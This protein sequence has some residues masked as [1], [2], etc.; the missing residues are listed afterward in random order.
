LP[1]N[2][3]TTRSINYVTGTPLKTLET[4]HTMKSSPIALAYISSVYAFSPL[5]K[6][7]S[8]KKV[9]TTL[10]SSI[11]SDID[12]PLRDPFGLYP[13]DSPERKGGLIDPL[14]SKPVPNNV[15]KD[16]LNLYKDKSEVDG[17]IQMSASLPFL[18]RPEMLDGT[19]PGDRGF[20]PFNFSSDKDS[21][22]WYRYAEIKHSRLAMLVSWCCLLR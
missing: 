11:T 6:G 14:E 4:Q 21:L 17:T 2:F 9:K 15:I 16:P 5:M 19:L 7:P 8:S 13:K 20:D 22:T 12:R 1:H 18:K 3:E 10:S